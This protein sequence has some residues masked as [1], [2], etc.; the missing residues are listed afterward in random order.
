MRKYVA[1]TEIELSPEQIVVI[2]GWNPPD[3]ELAVVVEGE[4]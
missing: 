4:S 1:G 2:P 3:R